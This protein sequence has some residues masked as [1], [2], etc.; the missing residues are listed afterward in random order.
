MIGGSVG[1]HWSAIPRRGCFIRPSGRSG[2]ARRH[3]WAGS[4]PST[5][6]GAESEPTC[7]CGRRLKGAGRPRWQGGC[8]WH[9]PICWRILFEGHYPHVWA[10]AWYPWAFWAF[11]Q[12]R[13]GHPRGLVVLP[14]V[15]ALTFFAGHP[16][17]WLLLVLALAAWGLAD[18][19]A[20]WRRRG[21]RRAVSRLMA[22]GAAAALSLGLCAID[23]APQLAAR[24]WLLRDHDARARVSIPRRY[25]L[26]A[27]NTFQLLSPQALGG[28]ADYF[29]SDNY[30]ET[31]LSIGLI[32]LLLATVAVLEH[33]DRKLVRGWLALVGVAFWWACG[34]HLLLYSAAYLVLPGMSGFR[35]PAR[36]LFL[37]NLGAAVLAGL[38]S[39]DALGSIQRLPR[40]FSDLP[41]SAACS[42]RL[43]FWLS[44]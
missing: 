26:E 5:W 7:C 30:W 22:F 40:P 11:G 20:I 36:A 17:E 18:A 42:W 21:A 8:T 38:G 19:W 10:A 2:L 32:P 44:V 16:Q 35:A 12:A 27:L 25:H 28:P 39:A 34:R 3:F 1:G 13:R 31:L 9:R 37:A 15:L 43:S 33:P 6:F 41:S 4:P 24:P 14:V 29:G 23:L